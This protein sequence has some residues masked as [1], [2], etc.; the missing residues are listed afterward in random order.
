MATTSGAAPF[1]AATAAEAA[2]GAA[3]EIVGG[4]GASS[5]SGGSDSKLRFELPRGAACTGDSANAGYR[6]Q[7]F[8][9]PRS[10]NLD[11][12]RFSS[13]GPLPSGAEIRQP[14]F[15]ADGNN[16]G[17]PL[18]DE[19]TATA[20]PV[21][22][23][24]PIIQPLPS[25]NFA[26]FP[27]GFLQPGDYSV[28]IACTLGPPSAPEQL[29]KYWATGLSIAT[30]PSDPGPA[31]IRFT[32]GGTAPAASAGRSTQWWLVLPV[33]GV[34]VLALLIASR[35]RGSSPVPAHASTRPAKEIR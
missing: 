24:G 1:G 19:Q 6:I 29:D 12:L 30:D 26:V 7:S 32:A 5:P 25:F 35:R 4:D 28:G 17:N 11:S 13:E 27:A 9:V 20:V 10:V 14:L 21:G 8:L 23:P 31:K 33:A 22:G 18:I 2:T 3:L 34:A 15:Q 16:P